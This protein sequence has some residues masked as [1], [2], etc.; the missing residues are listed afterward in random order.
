ML[1]SYH[2]YLSRG[3][4]SL[5]GGGPSGLSGEKDGLASLAVEF[6]TTASKTRLSY[7]FPIPPPGRRRNC[8][9]SD[10][11]PEMSKVKRYFFVSFSW[12]F[13]FIL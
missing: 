12:L 3:E 6:L 8:R 13:T 5:S 10:P 9:L 2:P 11:S 7:S 4:T 1:A